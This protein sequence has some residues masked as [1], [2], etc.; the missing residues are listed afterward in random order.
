VA[1][2]LACCLAGCGGSQPVAYDLAA[3][4]PTLART[5]R[6]ILRIRQPTVTGDLDSDR[7]L[8]RGGSGG[9]A[10]MAGARWADL[11]PLLLR[12]RLTTTFQNAHGLRAV[13]DDA[14]AANDYDVQTDVRAFELDARGKQVDVEIRVK[15]VSAASGRTVASRVFKTEAP[16]ASTEPAAVAAA[17]DRALSEVMV[18]IVGF[19]AASA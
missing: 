10:V 2:A 5:P 11:L 16:V 7:I 15:L 17:L 18:E 8:V 3:A 1:I 9:L 4:T 14:P 12:S 6:A 13:A 19:V